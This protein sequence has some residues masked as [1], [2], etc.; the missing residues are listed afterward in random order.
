MNH[1]L[2]Q[3]IPVGQTPYFICSVNQYC[4]WMYRRD[5]ISVSVPTKW[6]SEEPP[7]MDLL[8][9][10]LWSCRDPDSLRDVRRFISMTLRGHVLVF[11]TSTLEFPKLIP[12]VITPLWSQT[13]QTQQRLIDE[14]M[15]NEDIRDNEKERSNAFKRLVSKTWAKVLEMDSLCSCWFLM[16]LNDFCVACSISL[17]I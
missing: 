13:Q 4:S 8:L 2:V 14:S 7:V 3:F 5:C 15:I 10:L 6:M 16:F 1:T 17:L 12:A 9:H 11:L